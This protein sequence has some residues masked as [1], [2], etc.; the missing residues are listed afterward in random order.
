MCRKQAAAAL[1]NTLL[2]IKP[3]YASVMQHLVTALLVT[4]VGNQAI[5]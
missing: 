5:K 3:S 2:A 4:P 1:Q